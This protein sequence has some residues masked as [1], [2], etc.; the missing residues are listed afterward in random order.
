[1]A[2]RAPKQ[3]DEPAISDIDFEANARDG[4][5]TDW[6]IRYAEIAPWYSHAEKFAGIA[7]SL[8]GLPQLPDGDFQPAMALNC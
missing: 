6:P 2:I 1:M 4:V 7:G 8:E 3:H 5:G